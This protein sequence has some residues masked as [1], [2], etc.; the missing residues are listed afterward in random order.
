MLSLTLTLQ[1]LQCFSILASIFTS[2][3]QCLRASKP[4]FLQ[5]LLCYFEV[6][7][8]VVFVGLPS[9]NAKN[10]GEKLAAVT[11]ALHLEACQ[12]GSTVRYIAEAECDSAVAM[13]ARELQSTNACNCDAHDSDVPNLLQHWMVVDAAHPSSVSCTLLE[14]SP[15]IERQHR[16]R[17]GRL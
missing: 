3:V 10:P 15:P 4:L 17:Y 8:W 14:I 6:H 1:H 2:I 11:Q 9:A 13:L 5:I 16:M 12:L 7:R